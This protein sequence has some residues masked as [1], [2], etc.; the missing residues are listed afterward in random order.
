MT[1]LEVPPT[2]KQPPPPSLHPYSIKVVISL[3]E[4][5]DGMEKGSEMYMDA[6]DIFKDP[7]N[8]EFL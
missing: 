8:R 2:H 4:E 7:L 3:L 5:M 6:L 1:A